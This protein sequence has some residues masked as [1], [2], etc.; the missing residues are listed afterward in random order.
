MA[1]NRR[2]EFV[3]KNAIANKLLFGR[4]SPRT[5][6]LLQEFRV[7]RSK[8]DCVFVN[9]E[10]HAFEIKTELD[11]PA[12]L[13]KQLA[14]YR[15]VFPLITVITHAS[16]AE[17]YVDILRG[18]PVGVTVLTE[19]GTLR[20]LKRPELDSS[21]LS[22]E[23]MLRSLRKPE[24]T[25]LIATAFGSVPD[26]PN[27]LLFRE[28]LNLALD[29]PVDKIF[30]LWVDQLRRR[31]LLSPDLLSSEEMRPIRHICT[32]VNPDESAARR[33]QAWLEGPVKN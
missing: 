23:A 33:L 25:D 11:S 14:D 22:S 5:S 4:H 6:L 32:E 15:K 21:N 19:Q 7:G 29:L 3:Y 9:G 8:V 16:I 20:V 2:S 17:R 1:R 27:T 18:K 26:A 31:K 30:G 28:C 13:D 12:K 24:Y 10:V